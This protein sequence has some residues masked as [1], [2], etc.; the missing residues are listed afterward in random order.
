MKKKSSVSHLRNNKKK[1]YLQHVFA[2]Q[3]YGPHRQFRTGDAQSR[4]VPD[5]GR[6]ARLVDH[7]VDL[8]PALIVDEPS[9]FLL[10]PLLASK[11]ILQLDMTD[12]VR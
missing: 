2:R 12:A 6:D 4:L 5:H 7:I 8:L 9:S 11:E 1:L 10:F 3:K